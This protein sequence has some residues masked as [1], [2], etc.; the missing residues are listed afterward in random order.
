MVQLQRFRA[1]A[2]NA[3]ASALQLASKCAGVP[4]ANLESFN[5][6]ESMDLE[7]AEAVI[8][9]DMDELI[10]GAE[11]EE[12]QAAEEKANQSTLHCILDQVRDL[13]VEEQVPAESEED[14]LNNAEASDPDAKMPDGQQ[15]I[16]LMSG[17]SSDD[18]EKADH[19]LKEGN[20]PR[21][22]REVL[23]FGRCLAQF[24]SRQGQ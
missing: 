21:T 4:K 19:F 7:S 22:L 20:F 5:R 24:S 16:D 12:N 10:E 9:D 17:T 1:C 14:F 18:A 11:E 15:L 3:W 6:M 2:A 23:P 8:W 13:A